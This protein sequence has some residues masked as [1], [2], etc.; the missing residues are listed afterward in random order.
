M[1][2]LTWTDRG[3][4][5]AGTPLSYEVLVELAAVMVAVKSRHAG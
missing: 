3:P 4:G 2:P 1:L 5:A